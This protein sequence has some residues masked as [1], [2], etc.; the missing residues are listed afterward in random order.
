LADAGAAS[1]VAARAGQL[2]TRQVGRFEQG[3]LAFYVVLQIGGQD[4]DRENH[5]SLTLPRGATK[6]DGAMG[7]SEV[8]VLGG[9]VSFFGFLA[10]LLLR[11]SPLAMVFP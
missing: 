9:D 11:C 7:R 6:V 2:H 8:N 10:I 1:A 3:Q 5:L 4:L